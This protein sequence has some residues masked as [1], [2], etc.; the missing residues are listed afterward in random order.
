M[1]QIKIRH[2]ISETSEEIYIFEIYP[3]S[4]FYKGILFSNR[5]S[6]DDIWGYGY[7]DYLNIKHSEEIQELTRM[8]DNDILSLDEYND[9]LD[10]IFAPKNSKTI[11]NKSRLTGTFGGHTEYPPKIEP[12]KL[13]QMIIKEVNSLMERAE[14]RL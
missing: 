11:H 8:F 2:E 3:N 14:L 10:V 5:D 1:L 7:E 6:K 12:V 9:R 13:K 4:I